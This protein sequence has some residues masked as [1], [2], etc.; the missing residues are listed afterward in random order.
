MKR[1]DREPIG[2]AGVLGTVESEIDGAA[3]DGE[4]NETDIY[5]NHS[6]LDSGGPS[7]GCDTRSVLK[8]SGAPTSSSSTFTTTTVDDPT[9]ISPDDGVPRPDAS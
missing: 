4:R 7:D 6:L 8:E 3:D 2:V 1:H 5:I 9:T